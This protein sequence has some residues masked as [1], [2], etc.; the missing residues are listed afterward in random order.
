MDGNFYQLELL[1]ELEAEGRLLCRTEVPMHLKHTDPVTRVD[2]ALDMRAKYN[3]DM[4][5]CRRVK[6]S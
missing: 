6:C 3:S 4:L 5:W 2:E 1:A